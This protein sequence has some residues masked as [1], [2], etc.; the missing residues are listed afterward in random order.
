MRYL[1]AVAVLSGPVA[2]LRA[3]APDP[4]PPPGKLL[5]I[6]GRRIH[7]L[8]SGAGS[9][10][11]VLEA[12][13]SAFAIDWT[14]VQESVARTNRVC[15][16]DRAGSGWSEPSTPTSRGTIVSDLHS[17]LQ[18]AAEAPP[19]IL[20]GASAGGLYV[21]QYQAEFPGDVVGM[22]LVDPATETRLFTYF[23]GNAVAIASLSA[24]QLRSTIPSGSV[25]VPRRA[26][27]TGTPFDRL[28]PPLYQT[29]IKLD[30]RLIATIPDTVTYE[31]RLAGAERERVRL[32][33]LK[34]LS[35]T[36]AH[37]L[38]DRPLVILT[39]GLES[40][41]ELQDAHAELTRLSTNSRHRVIP[42]AGHEIHLFAPDAVVQAIADVV[43]ALRENARLDPPEHETKQPARF[44]PAGCC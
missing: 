34:E 24:E 30:A 17:V 6:G 33:R 10:T 15:S 3:Q 22:V 2:I 14:L 27:Q 26:P 4:G 1:V 5:D 19:Y 38:A 32:A 36:Q 37:P 21:R 18:L 40:N 9:P 35:E 42:G 16:Y 31:A 43:K 11:V 23:E 7:L 44:A 25:D 41:Q 20:V 39:R 29:R 8:C 12:G 13:A 28:P